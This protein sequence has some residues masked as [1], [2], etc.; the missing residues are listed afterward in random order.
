MLSGATPKLI[1]QAAISLLRALFIE[2]QGQG[3]FGPGWDHLHLGLKTGTRSTE[4]G[5]LTECDAHWQLTVCP[6]WKCGEPDDGG[7]RSWSRWRQD[8]HLG[9]SENIET[10]TG[11]RLRSDKEMAAHSILAVHP[12]ARISKL[13]EG[14]NPDFEVELPDGRRAIA[15]ATMH[16][17]GQRRALLRRSE[18]YRCPKLGS[19]W[20]VAVFDNRLVENYQ[21]GNT[22]LVDAVQKN[23][24]AVL[25]RAEAGQSCIDDYETVG[26]LC[27]EEIDRAPGN[28]TEAASMQ[29]TRRLWC[30]SSTESRQMAMAA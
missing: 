2:A 3:L 23:L 29:Q 25:A 11:G 19:V 15:E 22:F 7:H 27:E 21:D 28:G 14:S 20:Y 10:A 4:G 30:A 26:A 8:K 12:Q 6:G 16:T 17:D 24:A 18:P 5:S 13:A 9:V 1:N